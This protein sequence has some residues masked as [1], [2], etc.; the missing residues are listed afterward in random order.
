MSPGTLED[1]LARLEK[2][3]R[4]GGPAAVAFSGGVDSSLLCA[5][6]HAVHGGA[7]LA[8]T[9]D[10]PLLPRRELRD[11]KEVAARVGIRPLVIREQGIPPAVAVNPPDRCYHC[12]KAEFALIRE[13]ARGLG[14]S[15]VLD[16]SNAD[17]AADYR[18]GARALREL[19]VESP[20]RE[21][22]MTKADIR[23]L[24]RRF[25]LPTWDKPASACLA[26]RVPYGET[27]DGE[28]LSRIEGAEEAL[29]SRG[30]RQ[31]RVRVHGQVARIE[32]APEERHLLFD[33]T[34]LD[35]ISSRLKALGFQYVCLELEGYRMG[36]LNRTLM[37]GEDKPHG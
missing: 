30:L 28:K 4:V 22:G 1:R 26:S 27:V 14:I 8:V 9:I 29:R 21:A 20:L 25:G 23:E 34:L 12:K 15:R 6:A 18:P 36:S 13:T 32:V 37:T 2:A 5:V 10:S 16:G 3:L 31:V 11:A 17:D 33:T 19:G 24:S 7:C 35:D